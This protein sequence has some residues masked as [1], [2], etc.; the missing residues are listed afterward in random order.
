MS[1]KKKNPVGA[2][3]LVMII[4][5]AGKVLGLL[6]DRL[7]TVNYGSGMATNAF[8]TASRIP[9]V[10][11]DAVFASAIAASFIPVFNDIYTKEGKEPAFKF[12]SNFISVI[13]LF[14]AVLSILGMVFTEPLATFFADGYDAE[15]MALCVELTRILFPTVLFTGLAYSFVGI[16]QSMGKFN[17]PAL[18]SVIS[19]GIIIVYYFTLNGKFGIFGLAVAFLVGWFMQAAVQVPSLARLGYS[20]RP[21]F[22]I[23]SPEMKKVFVLMLPVMVSTWVQPINLTIN[24]KFGS[25]LFNGSGVSAIELA[26]NLYTIIASVFVLSVMNVIFPKLSKL[27]AEN[28]TDSF[29]DTVSG[30]MHTTMYFIMPM[31]GGLMALSSQIVSFIYGGGEFDAFSINITSRALFYMTIG[32]AGY[33]ASTVLSRAFFARQD[34]KTPLI[35]GVASIASNILLCILLVDK[36]DVAGLALAAAISGTVN[37]AILAIPLQKKGIGFVNKAFVIDFI[38]ITVASAIMAVGVWFLGD[39][40]S[41]MFTGKLGVLISICLP[42][43]AGVIVYIAITAL[44]RLS[45]VK[46]MVSFIKKK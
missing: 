12:S 39:I 6:R 10:F 19:N 14:T 21:D 46:M 23:L 35:A 13:G 43:L 27:N 41:N 2:I 36:Y 8:L 4:T 38:K 45:E 32:M 1:E 16:L 34:G 33:A 17:I 24:T 3:S 7:L 22:R 40:L 28:N 26:N 37:A 29:K 18:I 20:Y 5:L 15:T 42:A 31:T 11:F 9:R 25:H 30:T 44:L